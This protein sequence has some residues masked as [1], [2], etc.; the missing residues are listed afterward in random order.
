[1]KKKEN[2]IFF[3]PPPPDW[4]KAEANTGESLETFLN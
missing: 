4:T 1:M 2:W 3:L